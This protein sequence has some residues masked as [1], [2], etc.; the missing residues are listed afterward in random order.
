[1]LSRTEDAV[2]TPYGS[3]RVKRSEGYGVKRI[4]TE[5]DDIAR[6]AEEKNIS[7]NEARQLV[8]IK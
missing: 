8:E 2:E 4:K 1:M 7:I 3:V 6:I 5:Y